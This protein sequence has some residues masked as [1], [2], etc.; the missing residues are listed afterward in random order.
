MMSQCEATVYMRYTSKAS[1]IPFS[2]V[3]AP[4]PLDCKKWNKSTHPWLRLIRRDKRRPGSSAPR[5]C[6]PWNRYPH[7]SDYMTVW[8]CE[9]AECRDCS[10]ILFQ[11]YHF[12]QIDGNNCWHDTTVFKLHVGQRTQKSSLCCRH[13][14]NDTVYHLHWEKRRPPLWLYYGQLFREIS[15]RFLKKVA[16]KFSQ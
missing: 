2:W 15:P 9:S 5:P 6:S 12:L 13:T 7:H 4:P 14:V 11:N 3:N 16:L 8:E 10:I 1:R